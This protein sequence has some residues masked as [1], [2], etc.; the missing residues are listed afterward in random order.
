MKRLLLLI[1]I[2]SSFLLQTADS[3]PRPRILGVAHVAFFVSDLQKARDFYET[4]LGFAEAYALKAKDG[5]ERSIVIKINDTQYIEL[6]SD[7]PKED[8]RLAHVAFYTDDIAGMKVYLAS[9]GVSVPDKIDKGRAGNLAFTIVDPEGHAVEFVQYE[10]D[11]WTSRDKGKFMPDTRVGVRIEHVGLTARNEDAEKTFYT[12]ILG[13]RNQGK[14]QVAEGE[15]RIEFGAYHKEPTAE[16]RGSRN[17]LCLI[18]S[19]SVEKAVD[20]LTSRNTAITVETHDLK[21]SWH[22][23]V[24]DPDG[25]RIEFVDR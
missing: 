17:H 22:A 7:K 15:E 9:K 1:L 3:Q 14:P 24:N 16:F 8:G 20:V 13:F 5:A 25:T 10:Q 23:N 6:T 4:Y 18:A 11:S 2:T 12:D 21:K 19:P